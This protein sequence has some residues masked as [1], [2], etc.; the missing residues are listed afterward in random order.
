[1]SRVKRSVNAR[2]KRRDTPEDGEG[3]PWRC[4]SSLPQGQRGRAQADHIGIRDR[5]NRKRD[6]RRLMESSGS[7]GCPHQRTFLLAVHDGLKEAGVEL[8]RKVLA[9]MAVHDADTFRRFADRAREALAVGLS[10]SRHQAPPKGADPEWDGAFFSFHDQFHDRDADHKPPQRQAEDRAQAAPAPPRSRAAGP[11]RRRGR[12]S[13]GCGDAAGW[14]LWSASARPG[15]AC[16]EPRWR[17]TAGGRDRARI[18]DTGSRSTA[19]GGR[20]IVRSRPPA[21][22]YI[23]TASV[24]RGS[25]GNRAALRRCVR[26]RQRRIRRGSGRPVTARRP[27]APAWARSSRSPVCARRPRPAARRDRGAGL[28][29]GARWPRWQQ[30]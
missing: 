19:N 28:H 26:R 21:S 29:A 11:V 13:A 16:R 30:I 3:L 4:L 18:G 24:T 6:F 12:G 5:R 27:C 23:C 22:A 20:R 8:D 17:R 25:V 7:R 1:M 10:F 14:Q 9:D 2:K 15:A